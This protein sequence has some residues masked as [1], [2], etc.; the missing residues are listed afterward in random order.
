[1]EEKPGHNIV[2]P[3]KT[4]KA[5]LLGVYGSLIAGKLRVSQAVAN[6][7]SSFNVQLFRQAAVEWLIA[8]N[9]L[10]SEFEQLAFQKLIGLANPLAKDAL[11]QSYN[12]VSRYVMRYFDYLRLIVVKE[13][14]CARSKIHLSFD[15]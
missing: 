5:Q 8:N 15:G 6:E 11:W 12:S 13:L 4:P 10:L 14:S 7:L 9:Y 2:A 1:V 3:S